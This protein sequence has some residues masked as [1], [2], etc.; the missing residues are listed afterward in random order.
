MQ[1]RSGELLGQ[2]KTGTSSVAIY[3]LIALAVWHGAPSR[4]NMNCSLA[5]N[6]SRSCGMGL[7]DS[8]S[9]YYVEFVIP[10]TMC[11]HLGP[12]TL[13]IPHTIT[14]VGCFTVGRI[15]DGVPGRCHT[16]LF[17][18]SLHSNMLSSPKQTRRHCSTVHVA[19]AL[20]NASRFRVIAGVNFGPRRAVTT[21]QPI[22][23]NRR[24]T[25]RTDTSAPACTHDD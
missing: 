20:A 16:H 22:Y 13:I 6:H 9:R 15:G 19:W 14:L 2:S 4:M 3:C 21:L 8:T 18:A 12:F 1:L 24:C 7:R 23:R 11:S 25:V 10:S 17:P 5:A